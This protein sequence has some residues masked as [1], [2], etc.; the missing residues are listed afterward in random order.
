VNYLA[1]QAG[2]YVPSQPGLQI[3]MNGQFMSIHALIP[4]KYQ[5]DLP[6]ACQVRNLKSGKMEQSPSQKLILDAEA[7]STYWFALEN[8]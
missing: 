7:G 4:G 2:A 1:R 3:N 5:I 8:N 6:F